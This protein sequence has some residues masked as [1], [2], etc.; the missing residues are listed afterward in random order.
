MELTEVHEAKQQHLKEALALD[1]RNLA[2]FLSWDDVLAFRL[3]S[4]AL[5][6]I[7]KA[8]RTMPHC[9]SHALPR[10]MKTAS[11]DVTMSRCSSSCRS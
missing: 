2:V 3:A 7:T 8:S 11:C 4:N 1:V 6:K 9:R 5:N 10:S